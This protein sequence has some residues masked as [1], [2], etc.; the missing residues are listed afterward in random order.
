MDIILDENGKVRLES[1]LCAQLDEW[2]DKGQY[3]NIA[4]AISAVPRENWSNSLWFRL[5]SAYID[6]EEFGA[7]AEELKKMEPLCA[8]PADLSRFHYMM[9]YIC[10]RSDQEYRAIAEYRRGI[11]ADPDNSFVPKLEDEI[12]KCRDAVETKLARFRELA[13]RM[14]DDIRD[15]CNEKPEKIE[16][17]YEEFVMHLG[18]LSALRIIP[19]HEHSI[20]FH[21]YYRKYEG[22]EKQAALDWFKENF[23]VTDHESWINFFQNSKACNINSLAEAVR[24]YIAN[25]PEGEPELPNKEERYLFDCAAEF[26][27]TFNEYLPKAGVAAWD[28]SGKV[29][30]LRQAYA[31]DL[32]T[33]N[34]YVKAMLR[35]R[36]LAK[37]L[38]S[39]FEE[40]IRSLLFGSAF[41]MFNTDS[42]NIVSATRYM[43]NNAPLLING[44]LPH[45]EW[46]K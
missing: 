29:G 34:N 2:G 23:G 24:A 30:L 42:E 4:D 9:G 22:A 35:L 12:K 41:F 20:G 39:S 28:I 38:F 8:D 14:S 45:L 44:E 11:E 13:K 27:G 15:R 7:A 46:Q 21:E 36:D 43:C 32:I 25:G 5:I 19:G 6:L 31:C 1:P 26:I 33:P 16:L 37:E 3:R 40:Y 17:S 10:C 18:Y